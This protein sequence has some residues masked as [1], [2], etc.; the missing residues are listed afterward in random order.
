MYL[1]ENA[2]DGI[3]IEQLQVYLM[4]FAD[5]AVLFSETR[6][7]LQNHLNVLKNYCH[8]WNFTVNIPKYKIVVFRNFE[9]PR[10]LVL[11]WL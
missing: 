1:Q 5:D 10:S 6:E 3:N 7:G 9:P 11:L 8:K 4:L 2:H